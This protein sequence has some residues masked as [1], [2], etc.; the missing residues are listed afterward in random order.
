MFKISRIH[1]FLINK[2]PDVNKA[3]KKFLE[4]HEPLEPF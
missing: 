2:D 1:I 3:L 4:P